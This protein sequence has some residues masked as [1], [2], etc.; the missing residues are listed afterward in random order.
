MPDSIL[1]DMT[2]IRIA[3]QPFDPEAEQRTFRLGRPADGAVVSFLGLMRDLNAGEAVTQM[4]LEHYPGMT[5]K[6]LQAILD[7]A[8]QRWSLSAV[9][10]I[11]RVGDLLPQEPIVLVMVASCH[12]RESFNACE[13][14]MDYLKTRAPFWKRETGPAG[15]SRWVEGRVSDQNAANRWQTWQ[16]GPQPGITP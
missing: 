11:H 7:E 9:R 4:H 3:D 16:S 10:V 12:R 14:I 13:F 5:E 2:D 1:P 8:R 15:R 6:A